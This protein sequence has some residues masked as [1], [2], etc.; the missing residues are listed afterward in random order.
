MHGLL[1]LGMRNLIVAVVFVLE[2]VRFLLPPND[3]LVHS[4]RIA[5]LMIRL[6]T[7]LIRVTN[8]FHFVTFAQL[9]VIAR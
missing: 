3:R 2:H 9:G 8:V 6:S 4:Q 7:Q 1:V 5:T